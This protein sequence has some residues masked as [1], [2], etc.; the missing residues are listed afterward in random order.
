MRTTNKLLLNNSMSGSSTLHI[1]LFLF[2]YKH[3]QRNGKAIEYLTSLTKLY[4][5]Y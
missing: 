5:N 4:G 1:V 3:N 2:V